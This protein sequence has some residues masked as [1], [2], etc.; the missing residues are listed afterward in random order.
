[1]LLLAG[2]D[3]GWNDLI[4]RATNAEVIVEWGRQPSDADIQRLRELAPDLGI[5]AWWPYILKPEVF[6]IPRL[7]C[8]NFHPSL[9]PEGRGKHPNFWALKGR[10]PFGVTLHFIDEGIDTGDVA[11]QQEIP[12]F[13]E[14]T[15]ETLHGKARATVVD[16]FKQH[17]HSILAGDLPRHAQD[18]SAGAFHRARELEDASQIDL[19]REYRAGELLDLLRA[20]TYAAHPGAWFAEDG[21][22][23]EVRIEIRKCAN[24]YRTNKL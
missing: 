18:R 6:D 9:L 20:R 22:T 2:E 8:L 14:D 5:T 24:N 17:F 13:W 4:R 19:K 15:G 3:S 7:G 1:M 23:Y 10:T 21:E 12:V 11:F 16:L